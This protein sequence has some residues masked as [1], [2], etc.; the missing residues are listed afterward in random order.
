[1]LSSNAVYSSFAD[2]CIVI[3]VQ[4]GTAQEGIEMERYYV[5]TEDG[6]E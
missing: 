3:K 5:G 4:E 2:A 1:M 6:W